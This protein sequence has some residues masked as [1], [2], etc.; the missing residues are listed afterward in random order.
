MP[1]RAVL[2]D[3]GGTLYD[4]A[5]LAPAQDESLLALARWAG[6]DPDPGKVRQAHM[7]SLRRVYREYLVR[8][9]YLL[10]QKRLILAK[11]Q[12]NL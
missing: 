7:D 5:T 4:Y 10:Y 2:F 11:V 6:A 8:D 3:F 12:M 9:F 1:T